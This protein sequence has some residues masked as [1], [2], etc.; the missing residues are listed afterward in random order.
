[1]AKE[2]QQTEVVS[3]N[4]EETLFPGVGSSGG[5]TYA[6]N[7]DP[8]PIPAP[9]DEPIIRNQPRIEL[10]GSASIPRGFKETTDVRDTY[11]LFGLASSSQYFYDV[12][13]SE[14]I[15]KSI[16]IKNTTYDNR[17]N[18]GI[19]FPQFLKLTKVVFGSHNTPPRESDVTLPVFQ[20]GRLTVFVIPAGIEVRVDYEFYDVVGLNLARQRRY[21]YSEKMEL[22]VKVLDINSPV[23][24]EL[25]EDEKRRV[26]SSGV[27]VGTANL[28][29][30]P[31]RPGTTT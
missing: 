4:N 2:Y 24:V 10:I 6:G 20:T 23:Y 28:P 25:T 15:T 18:I 30:I 11:Q 5:G 19:I 8:E 12:G 21:N 27:P 7:T 3:T 29:D 16:F 26:D 17:L 13:S 22:Y 9:D 31:E 14:K 1:M